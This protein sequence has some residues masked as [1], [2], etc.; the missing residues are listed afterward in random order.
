MSKSKTTLSERIAAALVD[1]TQSSALAA[2]IAETEAA[3]RD[4]VTAADEARARALDP[5]V[6]DPAARS[7]MEDAEHISRR[8]QVALPQLRER[9]SELATREY[10]T[11]W[12][13][14]YEALKAERDALASDLAELYPTFEAR[15]ADLLPR[16][17]ARGCRILMK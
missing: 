13:T 1:D 4:A 9:R 12:R 8:L 6:V 15:I 16:I 11:R 10:L 5:T 2:L 17:A 3:A 7:A 14:D